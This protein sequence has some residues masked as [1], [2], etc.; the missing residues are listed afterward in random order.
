MKAQRG[1][2]SAEEKSA[3]MKESWAQGWGVI[4]HSSDTKE[5]IFALTERLVT[6]GRA[7]DGAF[8]SETLAA[9]DRLTS[10]GMWLVAHMTYAHRV[11]PTGNP[12]KAEDFK[13]DPEG[14]TGG[15]LNMVPAYVGYLAAN[16]LTG[17]TRGW[18]MGQGHCVAAIEAVNTLVGNL[19]SHQVGRYDRSAEG[20]SRLA[21]DFYSY[22]I[23]EDGRPAVPLGS[24]VSAHTA[25][26]ISEGGYLG[27][28][29]IEYVHMP[30]PGE[31]L[32]A[33]LSDGAFE[34]QR[35]GDWSPRWWRAEDSGT[36]VPIMILNGRRIEQRTEIAQE[37]GA[38]W[39][40]EHL[41]M[42]GFDPFD[43]DGH[44]PAA[45]AWAILESERRLANATEL[46]ASGKKIY[47]VPLPYGIARAI[48]G[49]GFPGAGTNRAHN[50]PLSG[51][52]RV[53]SRARQEFNT[54]AEKLF[55]Q[56]DVLDASV[57]AFNVHDAQDRPKE[58]NHALASRAVR[59][60]ELPTP[61]WHDASRSSSVSPMDAL[62]NYF[63]KILQKNPS[64][65]SRVGNPDELGSN[66]M[67]RTLETLKHRVNQPEPG[68]PESVD[69]GVITALNEE[70]VIGAALGNK[71]GL[72]LAVSY[73]AFAMKMLGA[74]R[75]EI[76]FTRHRREFGHSP[77]WIGVPLVV[78]SHTW[79]NGK[80][81]HSHQDPT[82]A[83]ALLGEM[84]DISR[85]MF[86]V[87][88]NSAVEA[89][90]RVYSAH[91]QV[92]CLVIPKRPQP[93]FFSCE[94]VASAFDCAGATIAGEPSDA[95]IQLVTIGA[96]QLREALRAWTRLLERGHPSCVSCLLEPA[97]LRE[98]RD[99][100]EADFVLDSALCDALYPRGILRIIV[101]HTRPEPMIGL[102]R[103]LDEG[104]ERTRALG[105]QNRGGT[106]DVGGM[107][108]ANRCT[109]A[110]ILVQAADLLGCRLEGLLD[111]RE[112]AAVESRGDPIAIL[113]SAP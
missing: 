69:G 66:H 99:N 27:F 52:P 17:T 68:L 12:L 6:E 26:G 97:R 113:K 8:V 54:G 55:V 36:V 112:I 5:R 93:N 60:P 46:I 102:L 84:S 65:R 34:E 95:V 19:S 81:E 74:I 1:M 31:S 50:L 40:H 75:Q 106:L 98:P 82:I 18:I 44:D 59:L 90:R 11:D 107:L 78:T 72:N 67:G 22:A 4:Q 3:S 70:A 73:E 25:G 63:V 7:A 57:T 83:E 88:A 15:S 33:F 16:V 39:L 49:F 105:Y 76:I 87:D 104:P 45:Y 10:A 108:F 13:A 91:G 109:W 53:D 62:D 47:P 71:G 30:L 21:G 28:A 32:V 38:R 94:N 64:L 85:V 89:L 9:A 35:G 20:L 56:A 37:G 111:H 110:H 41:R 29:E 100:Y 86:P 101:S 43:F 61:A 23:T 103:R 48:K 92:G 79:E 51:N 14:H 77:G 96:Y 42:S 58:G 2:G 80:N 24:H